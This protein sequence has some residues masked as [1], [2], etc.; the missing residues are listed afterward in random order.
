[1]VVETDLVPLDEECPPGGPTERVGGREVYRP[2]LLRN[3]TGGCQR[4]GRVRLSEEWSGRVR[5]G[6]PPETGREERQNDGGG[7]TGKN[8]GSYVDGTGRNPGS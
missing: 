3:V 4:V 8:V 6:R 7:E 1:M 2:D 5:S